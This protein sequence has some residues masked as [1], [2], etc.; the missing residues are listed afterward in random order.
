MAQ[1]DLGETGVIKVNGAWAT[2]VKF[3]AEVQGAHAGQVN[4]RFMQ[5]RVEAERV[6]LSREQA[7][8]L[9][10]ERNLA[11]I[12]KEVVQVKPGDLRVQGE[13]RAKDL[14]YRDVTL[15]SVE[16]R[17]EENSIA[18]S[19][20]REARQGKTLEEY[21]REGV[22]AVVGAKAGA[23][24]VGA[25]PAVVEGLD[26]AQKV[27]VTGLA[28]KA[29]YDLPDMAA[30]VGDRA[31]TALTGIRDDATPAVQRAELAAAADAKAAGTGD[32]LKR[33][34]EAER[35]RS[36]AAEFDPTALP[37]QVAAKY[38]RKDEKFY[39]ADR[40]LAFVD[41]GGA[42]TVK[43]ENLAVIK[44]VVA[45]AQARG[46]EE[47][48]VTGTKNFR[49]EVWKEAFAQGLQ[50]KG[51]TPAELELQAAEKE[52]TRRLG[53]NEVRDDGRQRPAP[54]VQ[55]EQQ[56][57]AAP[58]APTQAGGERG[59]LPKPA[60]HTNPAT[61]VVYGK[62]LEHAAAPYK[63]D[64]KNDQSYY[65]KLDPGDGKARTY[66]GVGLAQAARESQTKPEIG[67]LVGV[68][69]V[70]SKPVTVTARTLDAA[71]QPVTR[72]IDTQRNEW[73]VERADY[74]LDPRRMAQ[75]LAARRERGESAV[76]GAQ[77]AS[78]GASAP[79]VDR[80][81]QTADAVRSAQLTREELQ[82]NH[83]ELS[84]AVFN[85]MAAHDKFAD[86]FVKS[87]LIRQE[88]RAQVIATM[89]ERL[90]SQLERGE[91]ITEP[92]RKKITTIIEKSVLRAAD[93][94]GRKPIHT[95][96][97]RVAEAVRTPKTL[98]REDAQVRA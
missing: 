87:G 31:A 88:D 49:R 68:E 42:L 55:G 58:H 7:L 32:D 54:P 56:K 80:N 48:A 77:P 84:A 66:W 93:E 70:G 40:T 5:G 34:R 15:S 69:Q 11:A 46:W 92:D 96:P 20:V 73:V 19:R 36:N 38:L 74:F 47:L 91:K 39:F 1:Q 95:T 86:A 97:D 30:K 21:A 59:D 83:P 24:A 23:V 4:L 17:A 12:D 41:K 18:V 9:L 50:V 26:V 28:G 64:A 51:Y 3:N 78:A 65:V 61:G 37:E 98:V 29:L 63:F 8:E 44:D 67:A 79:A 81:K 25:S 82:R 72:S 85:Q 22:A 94:V 2:S 43:T 52:R 16:V 53:P 57:A 10:G 60:V 33:R 14:H 75:D 6:T 76:Q 71:G 35:Q 90:A 27:A 45:I 62:L 89:R 13:L